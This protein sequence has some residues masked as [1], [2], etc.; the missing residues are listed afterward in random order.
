[1][2]QFVQAGPVIVDLLEE[3]RLRG[4]LHIILRRD[5]IGAVPADAEVDA[6]RGDHFLGDRH[7]LALGQGRRIGREAGA[8]PFA[9]RDI[10]HGETL[11]KG[12]GAGVA[13][14]VAG[15]G[16]FGFGGEAVGID[17]SGAALA[18]PDRAAR[19]KCLPEG[20]PAL[21]WVAA[22]DGRAP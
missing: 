15:A 12:D 11:Q 18:L 14:L 13:A 4:H 19:L 21:R 22:R 10:E 20:Q 1:M 8:Q 7:D 2:G 6:A 5:I 9:L 16:L 17:D 3:G